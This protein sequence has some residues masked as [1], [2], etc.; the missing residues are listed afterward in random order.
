MRILAHA[1]IS[2]ASLTAQ[3]TVPRHEFQTEAGAIVPL[4]GYKANTYSAGPALR[5]SYE[6][7]FARPV[8]AEIG[9]TQAWMPALEC[10]RF[11]CPTPIEGVRFLDFGLRGHFAPKGTRADLS[12][13]LGGGYVWHDVYNY[14]FNEPL[15]QF[16]GKAMFA[17]DR[18]R[19]LRLSLS[20]RHWRDLGRPTQTWL[21][22]AG[23]IVL[24]LNPH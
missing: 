11:S 2:I 9:F 13:G 17:L 12:I 19:R 3:D 4:G 15:L 24:G 14:N 22:V 18:A 7:R 21:S 1:A 8:G 23:G 6:F 16:S 5:P 10:D 20:V